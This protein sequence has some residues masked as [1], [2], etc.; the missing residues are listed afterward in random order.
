MTSKDELKRNEAIEK[1]SKIVRGK[2][3]V[4]SK[5][6]LSKEKKDTKLLPENVK[7]YRGV[8]RRESGRWEQ[9]FKMEERMFDV[10]WELLI[11]L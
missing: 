5:R 1:S 6:M 4:F 11:L 7:K 9:R 8:R 2:T 3:K 10:G